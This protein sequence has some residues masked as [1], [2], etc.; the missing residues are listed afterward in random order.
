[1]ATSNIQIKKICEWCKSEFLSQKCTTRYCCKRC[2]EL[3]Y[4]ERKRQ[5]RKTNTESQIQQ[6]LQEKAHA[7]ISIREY[8]SISEAAKLLG[9]TRD[10]VYK[11]I[12]RGTLIAYK[13]SSRLT[14]ILRND[15]DTMLRTRFYVRTP[16]SVTPV[17]NENGEP[18]TEFYTTKEIIEKF[19]VSNLWVFAQAK[20]HNIPKVY[21]RGKTLWSKSHCNRVF[22]EKPE[23]PKEDDWISYSE[24]RAEY[25]LTH[26]QLHNYVKYHW[27]RRKKVGKYTYI[28][29]SEIDAILRP[30][31]L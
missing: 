11:L 4:K 21:H 30:S 2:A 8:L 15:I 5:E 31:T 19:G 29:K 14:V 17:T 26:D 16:R 23:P 27:L 7:E 13:I 6:Q 25:G 22:A 1:M 10:G 9:L 18:I 20:R 28:L 3:A 24:V 12:Y